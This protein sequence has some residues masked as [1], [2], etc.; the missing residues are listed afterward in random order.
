[1]ANRIKRI[2]ATALV[3]FFAVGPGVATAVEWVT[4]SGYVYHED[5]YGVYP[6][7]ALVLINGQSQFSCD[8]TGR[9]D[10]EVPL[11]ENGM[12]M[13]QAFAAGNFSPARAVVTPEE[14]FEYSISMRDA[15]TSDVPMTTWVVGPSASPD[16][17]RL[18]GTVESKTAPLCA[19]VLAN[20]QQQFT[21]GDSLGV[22]GLDVPLD[23]QGRITLQAFAA[24]LNSH[25]RN[26]PADPDT[27]GDYFKD[28]IDPDDD[29]DGILD[30]DDDCPL[31]AP[32]EECN[33]GVEIVDTVFA[34]GREWAQL[35]LLTNVSWFDLFYGACRSYTCRGVLGGQDVTGWHWATRADVQRLFNSYLG[36]PLL[37]WR[38]GTS[39]DYQNR[40]VIS[41]FD[42]PDAG[43]D[44]WK[45]TSVEQSTGGGPP[46]TYRLRGIVR[47]R[48]GYEDYWNGMSFGYV[49]NSEPYVVGYEHVSSG[50][51]ANYCWRESF[52]FHEMELYRHGDPSV[53]VWLYRQVATD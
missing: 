16:R 33:P 7:C 36:A 46:T 9:Y 24:G 51:C 5:Q 1:M 32:P 42:S 41:I 45:W 26:F 37:D 20:G 10:M 25:R 4:A 18:T 13:I 23:R 22:Y 35:E 19:L 48:D 14:A 53:G 47:D 50:E 31:I 40:E 34:D 3:V 30:V 43:K 8:G 52:H 6:V 15:S 44:G 11:D 29:N 12:V 39:G 49:W 27:D 17:V 28:S 21:C 38:Y 2:A